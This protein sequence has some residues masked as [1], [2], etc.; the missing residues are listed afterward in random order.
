MLSVSVS[1]MFSQE[2][3]NA[4]HPHGFLNCQ[5]PIKLD[6]LVKRERGSKLRGLDLPQR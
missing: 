3:G 2:D 5:K 6:L 4:R 1:C